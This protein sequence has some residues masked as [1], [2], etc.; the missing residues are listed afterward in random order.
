MHAQLMLGH[1]RGPLE[2]ATWLPQ[3][4]GCEEGTRGGAFYAEGKMEEKGVQKEAGQVN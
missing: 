1:L 2:G 3:F 4:S